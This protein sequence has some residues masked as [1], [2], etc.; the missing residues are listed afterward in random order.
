MYSD[1]MCRTT[2]TK[3]IERGISTGYD[4]NSESYYRVYSIEQMKVI[5]SRDVKLF[6]ESFVNSRK[7]RESDSQS[8]GDVVN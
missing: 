1:V 2:T 8:V 5:R 4:V 6:D 7:L 3:L